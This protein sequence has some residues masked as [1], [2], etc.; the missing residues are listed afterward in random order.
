MAWPS[1]KGREGNSLQYNSTVMT[2]NLLTTFGRNAPLGIPGVAGNFGGVSGD[3]V[4]S[5]RDA[6]FSGDRVVIAG[7]GVDHESFVRAA[8][9]LF[10]GLPAS[11]ATDAASAYVGGDKYTET[12][13]HIPGGTFMMGSQVTLT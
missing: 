5:F 2:R 11:G 12:M 13:V 1:G 9:T 8:E 10:D 7:T 3:A 6:T 4:R